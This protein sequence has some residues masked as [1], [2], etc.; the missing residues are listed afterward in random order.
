[1]PRKKGSKKSLQNAKNDNQ[2]KI[3]NQDKEDIDNLH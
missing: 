3:E 2:I 1:M